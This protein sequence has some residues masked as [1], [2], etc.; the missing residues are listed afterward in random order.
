MLATHNRAFD[1]FILNS[2][3]LKYW[4]VFETVE[5]YHNSKTG[6]KPRRRQARETKKSQ[7]PEGGI[8]KYLRSFYFMEVSSF[9]GS[10]KRLEQKGQKQGSRRIF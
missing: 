10:L 5:P 1:F 4:L 8:T 2:K 7:T 3:F 6:L 9:Y